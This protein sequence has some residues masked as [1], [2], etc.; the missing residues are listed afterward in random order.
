M[1]GRPVAEDAG[2]RV[3]GSGDAWVRGFEQAVLRYRDRASAKRWTTERA[4]W[5]GESDRSLDFPPARPG[6][7][8]VGCA[9]P[10][11]FRPGEA[12]AKASVRLLLHE[13]RTRTA[14]AG[15]RPVRRVRCEAL[16]LRRIDARAAADDM[17]V[18]MP[19]DV[20]GAAVGLRSRAGL[21]LGLLRRS[22]AH[23]LH[24]AVHPTLVP[25]DLC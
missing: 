5:L 6:G 19:V 1:P 7:D 11:D 3:A 24:G 10:V 25:P 23:G 9:E 16:R 22:R 17:P 13:R 18:D 20:V 12:A 14:T 4:P 8:A 21:R 2:P 15:P